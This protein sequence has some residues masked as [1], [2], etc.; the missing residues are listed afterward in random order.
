MLVDASGKGGNCEVRNAS[1]EEAIKA[2]GRSL[3]DMY[4]FPIFSVRLPSNVTQ[5]FVYAAI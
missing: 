4:L 2:T 5:V 1:S 3:N